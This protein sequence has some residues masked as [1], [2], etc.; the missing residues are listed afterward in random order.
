[1]RGTRRFNGGLTRDAHAGSY[2]QILLIWAVSTVLLTRVSLALTGYPRLGLG[3]LHVAHV[4]WGGLLMVAALAILLATL[5][6]TSRRVAAAVGGVG[7]GLFIDE[8]GKFI[9]RDVD[10]FFQPAVALIYVVFVAL[11]LLFRAVER[12][13]LSSESLLANAASEMTEVVLDGASEAEVARA[14]DLLDRSGATGPLA[15]GLRAAI[16]GAAAAPVRPPSLVARANMAMGRR[17]RRLVEWRGFQRVVV[18][19]LVTQAV[20]GV[21]VVVA[22]VMTTGWREPMPIYGGG[23]GALLGVTSSVVSLVFVIVGTLRLPRSRLAAYRWYERSLLIAV[24][25]TQVSLFWQSQLAATWILAWNL[26]LLGGLA[27]MIRQE[28]P[29]TAIQ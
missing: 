22:S 28:M 13:S 16:A 9:S 8:L 5:G 12:R 26:L 23:R 20:G 21:A 27:T 7:F 6:D 1:M 29:R 2:L 25:V 24:F 19:L 11:F 15:D 10:Y 18:T 4:L 3:E 17:Y 14:L